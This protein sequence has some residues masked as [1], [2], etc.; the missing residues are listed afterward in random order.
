MI[1]ERIAKKFSSFWSLQLIGWGIFSLFSDINFLNARQIIPFRI[2]VWNLLVACLGLLVTLGFRYFYHRI[3]YQTLPIT[4]LIG[5]IIFFTS[6]GANVWWILDKGLDLIMKRPGDTLVPSTLKYYFEYLYLWGIVLFAWSALYFSIKFWI[7]WAAQKE[8]T[9]CAKVL[10]HKA[11]LQTLRYQ[12]NP[13][14]L[15]NTLNAIR[16]LVE[17]NEKQAKEM[18][19]ELSEFLRY[20]LISSQ[21]TDV[22]LSEEIEAIR[23]YFAIEKRRYENKLDVVIDVDPLAEDFPVLSFLVHPLV[24]N[25]I[26]YGMHSSPMPLHISISAKVINDT[27]AVEVCNTGR[28]SD[29]IPD[30]NGNGQNGATVENV[31]QRLENAFP[32]RHRFEVIEKKDGMCVRLEI[33]QQLFLQNKRLAKS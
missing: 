18:I 25:A 22:P 24:E 6:V 17:E 11:Q 3:K 10:A 2:I 33:S 16:A 9:E 15:F 21:Y 19:T 26:R 31:R 7:N 29:P 30:K 5:I 20:S 14:F 23:H 13:H 27:L 32:N 12:I 28:W 8:T 1:R 4:Y